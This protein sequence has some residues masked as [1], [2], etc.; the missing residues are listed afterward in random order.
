MGND[1]RRDHSFRIPRPD[2]SI[3]FGTPNAC[4][5]CHDDKSDQWAANT[6]KKWYGTER[7][8][9]FSDALL[10]SGSAE[11]NQSERAML[12]QF[13]SDLQ[14]PTIARAT[15]IEN[16]NYTN[17][18]QYNVLLKALNDSSAMMR[19][20]ALLKFRDLSP[21]IR[22]SIALKFVNDPV[23]MVRI[24]AAQ[25]VIGLDENTL[26]AN[27]NMNLIASR[28]ELETMLFSNADFSTGRMQ[29]GDYYLQNN[30]FNS[31]IM[32]YKMALQKDMNFHQKEI[33]KIPE[34]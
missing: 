3:T 5:G 23:K 33:Q 13:V 6:I 20:H 9:H 16:L 15:V 30:D 7:G 28:N 17:Q 11:L 1:F 22:T 14:F 12:D 18:D 31:A 24:G 4:T 19:Y 25:L 26:G 21:Q 29:L 8:K 10:L 34:N 2:Q 32:H 27:D